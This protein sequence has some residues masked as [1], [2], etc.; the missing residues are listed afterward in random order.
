MGP[1]PH[2]PIP[3]FCALGLWVAL[4]G[5]P[6]APRPRPIWQ[7]AGIRRSPRLQS[8]PCSRDGD[9]APRPARLRAPHRAAPPPPCRSA[10]RQ[11]CRALLQ[12]PRRPT[13]PRPDAVPPRPRRSFLRFQVLAVGVVSFILP[14]RDRRARRAGQLLPRGTSGTRPVVFATHHGPD[15]HHGLFRTAKGLA[16]DRQKQMS[17]STSYKYVK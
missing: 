12:L 8:A 15:P 7:V 11:A 6:R 5:Q 9:A 16:A 10:S 1:G 17:K 14:P 4:D 2:L 13:R 3:A